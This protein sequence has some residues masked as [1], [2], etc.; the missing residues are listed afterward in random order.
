VV[1]GF[2]GGISNQDMCAG[3]ISDRFNVRSIRVGDGKVG[4]ETLLAVANM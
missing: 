3:C 2:G 4:L 1:E